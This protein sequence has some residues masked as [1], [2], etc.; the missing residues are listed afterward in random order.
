METFK[1]RMKRIRLRAG[2]KSQDQA[3]KAIGCERGTVSMWEAPSSTVKSVGGEWLFKVARAYKVRPEWINNLK[4]A[5]DGFPWEPEAFRPSPH[6]ARLDLDTVAYA[7]A[8]VRFMLDGKGV[9]FDPYGEIDLFVLAYRHMT[10]D[11]AITRE[12]LVKAVD[13]NAQ[14]RGTNEVELEDRG[15]QL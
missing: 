8:A 2:F 1:D 11:P 3:R 4:S 14:A 9:A 5:N 15:G 6:P 7:K 12:E 10:G 13:S